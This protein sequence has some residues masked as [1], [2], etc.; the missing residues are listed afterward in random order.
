MPNRY[1]ALLGALSLLPG[2]FAQTSAPAQ[3]DAP[4]ELSPF[5]VKATAPESY[6][7]SEAV[8]GSRVATS[9]KDL[10]Y[11]VNVI[12]SEFLNDFDLF[13]LDQN[14]AY[15]SSFSGLDTQGNYNL[16]GFG[17]TFQLRNGFYRLGLIDRV[18]VD[19]IEIIKG[20]NAAI[21]GQTSPAGL[22][23]VITKRPTDKPWQRLSIT[24]GSNEMWRGE[25]NVNGPLGSVH[26]IDL[27]H[28]FSASA[29][30]RGDDAAYAFT[31]QRTLSEAI[32]AKAGDKTT[33]LLEYEYSERRSTPAVTSVPWIVQKVGTRYVYTSELAPQFGNF[34]QSGPTGIQNRDI[35]NVTAT[36]EHRFNQVWSARVSGNWYAR[37]AFNFNSSAGDQYDPLLNIITSR[38]PIR[39]T[40][41]EDGGGVQADLLAHYRTNGGKLEHKT[42]LTFDW[43]SNWR[44]RNET[45]P[46]TSVIGNT[47]VNVLNPVY[48]VPAES[49]WNITTRNDHTRNTVIGAY[50]RQQTSMLDGKLL[51]FGGVRYDYVIF[52][53]NF[54]DQFNVGGSKPGSLNNAGTRDHFTDSAVSPSLGLN[55]KLTPNLALF[56]NY[57]RSFF[58]NAQSSK[59]GDPRLP[60]ERAEGYDF[61]VKAGY[62]KDRLVFT[63]SGFSIVRNGVKATVIENGTAVDRAAG[64]QKADGVEF[65]F[66]WR[67]TDDLTLLG[68]YGYTDART[69][70]NGRDIDSIGRRPSG[71]PQDNGGL[72]LRYNFPGA[73]KGL[74]FT[75]GVKYLGEANPNSLATVSGGAPDLAR[76]NTVVPSSTTVDAGLSYR[77]RAE[78]SRFSHQVRVSVRN[79][80]N[81]DY[82]TPSKQAGESRQFYIAYTLSH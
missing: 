26:G 79:L 58:P 32:Q 25:L 6:L 27:A 10:P 4:M 5:E 67:V 51:A 23:N 74:A 82:L 64:Q 7:A 60:N 19:R 29:M 45:K 62:F 9:I 17:A 53:L 11:S 50:L 43:S 1:L 75:L 37:D 57:S 35:T 59:L 48:T 49:L 76:R 30:N 41:N 77:W 81:E 8:T 39:S 33:L 68:G 24:G 69:S 78:D 15:T 13:D 46:L 34:N 61:G 12:T 31:K 40:L 71:V 65:D 21:Y 38:N 56:A 66:T 70:E 52:D 14:M 44:Y 20:P 16:R 80:L 28:I 47:D 3:A 18:N 55:Y 72:A 2:V 22:V 63:L 73:L 42:L 36:L 54:G